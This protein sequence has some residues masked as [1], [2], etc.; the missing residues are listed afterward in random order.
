MTRGQ[1]A[2][3]GLLIDRATHG[4]VKYSVA[5]NSLGK[6]ED[7]THLASRFNFR[8]SLARV[9]EFL[10]LSSTDGLTN[11]LIDALKDSSKPLAGTNTIVS[12]D[13][14]A[15][16]SI[17]NANR[18]SLVSQNMVEKGHTQEQAEGEIDFLT[19]IV[20]HLGRAT[21]TGDT[22]KDRPR[23]SLELKLNLP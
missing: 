13:G 23:F 17:L 7:R 11:D 21:L 12:A 3:P 10:I 1:R 5:T 19:T 20:K 18:A 15:L 8:P 6:G 4:G 9:G 14:V 16:A 22:H 2:E